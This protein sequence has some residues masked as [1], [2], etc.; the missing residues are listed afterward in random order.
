MA[1]EGPTGNA[2][3]RAAPTAAASN[4]IMT[5]SPRAVIPARRRIAEK[6]L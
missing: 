3:I 2:S 6:L 5:F 4:L 1:P